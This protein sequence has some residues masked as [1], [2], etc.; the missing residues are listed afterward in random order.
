MSRSSRTV[1]QSPERVLRERCAAAGY[2]VWTTDA[3]GRILTEPPLG[4]TAGLILHSHA[5]N[6]L[7]EQHVM[8]WNGAQPP[9]T[10]ELWPGCG[11]V[12]L[13]AKSRG[14]VQSYIIALC[15]QPES[16]RHERFERL[17]TD[18]M[19][20]ADSMREALSGL[21][22]C[23][24]SESERAALILGRMHD[25]LCR[26][27]LDTRTIDG[28]THH[29][30]DAYEQMALL[31][32]LGRS[33]TRFTRPGEFFSTVLERLADTLHFRWFSVLIAPDAGL[34]TDIAGQLFCFGLGRLNKDEL[35]QSLW[36]RSTDRSPDE[37]SQVLSADSLGIAGGG[38]IAV[39][40]VVR[41][42][43]VVGMLVAGGKRGDDPQISSYDTKLMSSV[44]GYVGTFID[45][46]RLEARRNAMFVGSIQALT[47]IV[48]AKDHYT[49]GHSERVA[50]L[51][52][53]LAEAAG[54]PPET[55][56]RVHLS[57]LLHDVGKVGIPEVVLTKTSRLTE[58]EFEIIKRHP[59]MGYDI[60][61]GIPD[62][63]DILSGVLTHHERWDGRGYPD[64]ASGEAIPLFGRILCLADSFDAMSSNR[65]YRSALTREKVLNEI[66]S[67]AGS[68]F[69]PELAPIFASMDFTAFDEMLAI[70][71]TRSAQF[72]AA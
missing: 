39:Q 58:D 12:T 42:N 65:A 15:M 30:A 67:C 29:L 23:S 43:K 28:F 50:L 9:Q 64:Q 7:L 54:L 3:S 21:A 26:T 10:D 57:G 34:P 13:S 69:D 11:L 18:E 56:E 59:R 8:A 55:A 19:L 38:Q 6:Q 17:C 40:H 61:K 24:P 1:T 41:D 2:L 62:F 51:A 49:L 36:K 16:L 60:L 27:A 53:Q 72:K 45:N 32:E 68:Q 71:A 47:A 44:A 48:D 46:A 25:D 31:H 66:R 33:M 5:F 35:S 22:I 37:G 4:D 63:T 20:D 52:A 14:R 70:N